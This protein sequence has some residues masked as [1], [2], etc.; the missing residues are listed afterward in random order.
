[1]NRFNIDE[2]PPGHY[3]MHVESGVVL[4]TDCVM[5]GHSLTG[6]SVVRGGRV[7]LSA[8]DITDNGHEPISVEDA[9]AGIVGDENAQR[10]SARVGIDDNNFESI[11]EQ[12]ANKSQIDIVIH[13]SRVRSVNPAFIHSICRPTL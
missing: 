6:L 5:Y 10:G 1:M 9:F 4:V 11:R 2:V 8:C 13:G 7:Q 3:V 12:A